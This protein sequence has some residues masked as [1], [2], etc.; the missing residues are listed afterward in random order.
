MANMKK[1]NVFSNLKKFVLNYVGGDKKDASYDVWTDASLHRDFN[2][3]GCAAYIKEEGKEPY[4]LVSSI[5]KGYL[6]QG[7]AAS[8]FQAIAMV[9]KYL[10]NEAVVNLRSDSK[11]AIRYVEQIRKGKFK[12]K[13]ILK[14]F[15]QDVS[16]VEQHGSLSISWVSG[17]KAI[18]GKASEIQLV[19]NFAYYARRNQGEARQKNFERLSQRSDIK[20]K[21]I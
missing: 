17:N 5:P 2:L 14:N 4:V 3:V 20:Y 1:L 21:I 10:G 18:K 8:E 15:L 11:R 9:L 19:D 6:G 16:V 12:D 7:S 13:K